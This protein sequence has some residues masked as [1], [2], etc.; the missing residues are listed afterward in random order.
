[1]SSGADW[2]DL[3]NIDEVDALYNR[4]ISRFGGIAGPSKTGCVEGAV[5]NAWSASLY[6]DE[7]ADDSSVIFAAYVLYYLVCAHCFPDGNKRIGWICCFFILQKI[8][9]TITALQDEVVEFG[10]AMASG[11]VFDGAEAVTWIKQRIT[12]IPD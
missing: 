1:M 9:Y 2:E 6:A 7:L 10:L 5:G 11:K 12:K 3:L 8:G 4:N